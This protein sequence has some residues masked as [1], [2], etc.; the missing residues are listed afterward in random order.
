MLNCAHSYVKFSTYHRHTISKRILYV[1]NPTCN[2]VSFNF[3][4]NY[5]QM[6]RFQRIKIVQTFKIQHWIM[7]FIIS[8]Q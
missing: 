7:M 5:F 1:I 3:R 6:C 2:A 8:P 4:L